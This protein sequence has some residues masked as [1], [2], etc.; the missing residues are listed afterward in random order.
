M[1]GH[2]HFKHRGWHLHFESPLE[3]DFFILQFFDENVIDIEEQPVTITWQD[4]SERKRR[5]IPDARIDYADGSTK[6]FEVKP[7]RILKKKASEL[8]PKFAAA[9]NYA[10]RK[11]WKFCVVN[12]DD[13]HTPRLEN[14]KF[15][16]HFVAEHTP[17]HHAACFFHALRKNKNGKANVSDLLKLVA[18]ID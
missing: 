17:P 13:I 6:L 10:E 15:L 9:K 7:K 3:R 5:C 14:S 16:Y 18:S 8:A 1:Q 4:E 12:E 2:L 11:G